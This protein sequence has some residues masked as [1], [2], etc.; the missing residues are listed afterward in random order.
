[1]AIG[2]ATA[3][4]SRSHRLGVIKRWNMEYLDRI[5]GETWGIQA[6]AGLRS[7]RLATE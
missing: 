7:R 3:S 1:M 4:R 6:L 2:N 5:W